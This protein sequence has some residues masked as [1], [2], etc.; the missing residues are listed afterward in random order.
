MPFFFSYV[1][2]T[3][4]MCHCFTK[5]DQLFLIIG[6]EVRRLVGAIVESCLALLGW[7]GTADNHHTKEV[8]MRIS[9]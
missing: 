1:C 2:K 9:L 3:L 6:G 5:L 4:V 8:G 7:S